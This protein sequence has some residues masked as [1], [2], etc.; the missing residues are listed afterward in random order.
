MT[1]AVDWVLQANFLF[2]YLR[3]DDK[4]ADEISENVSFKKNLVDVSLFALTS[5]WNKHA[6]CVCVFVCLPAA[7][8]KRN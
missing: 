4:K 3:V 2:I 7:L 1:F 8:S 5:F 6:V